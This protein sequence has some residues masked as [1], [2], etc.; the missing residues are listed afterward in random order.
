MSTSYRKRLYDL[1]REVTLPSLYKDFGDCVLRRPYENI[2]DDIENLEV[3]D[4]DIWVASFPKSG[5]MT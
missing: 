4:E 3:R 1:R 5:K 2:K